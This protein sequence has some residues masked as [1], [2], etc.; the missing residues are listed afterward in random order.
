MDLNNPIYNF[1]HSRF[2]L[3]EIQISRELEN[4]IGQIKI[5]IVLH[6]DKSIK[7]VMPDGTF[8]EVLF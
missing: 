6:E 2:S 1:N 8:R 3:L 7:A 4:L 5:E